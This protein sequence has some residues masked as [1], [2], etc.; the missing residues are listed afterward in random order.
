MPL[1]SYFGGLPVPSAVASLRQRV[2]SAPPC[3]KT[4]SEN[5]GGGHRGCLAPSPDPCALPGGWERGR[6]ATCH[7]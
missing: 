3:G 2:P 1:L 5:A 4:G 7:H 6:T